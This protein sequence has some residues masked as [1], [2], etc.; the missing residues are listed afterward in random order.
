MRSH[1]WTPLGV[2]LLRCD[3]MRH[4]GYTELL[5]RY[6][7][8]DPALPLNGERGIGVVG[9]QT[10]YSWMTVNGT[11]VQGRI[12]RLPCNFNYQVGAWPETVQAG[13]RWTELCETGCDV[14]HGNGAYGKVVIDDLSSEPNG[15]RCSLAFARQ[16]VGTRHYP[17]GSISEMLLNRSARDCCKWLGT[18]GVGRRA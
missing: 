13:D 10:L 4:E 5:W 18:K 15:E 11:G 17:A 12:A 6:A 16:Q 9:D 8:H 7:S 14:L 2:Q 1:G 3:A